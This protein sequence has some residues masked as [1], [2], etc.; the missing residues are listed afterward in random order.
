MRRRVGEAAR[1]IATVAVVCMLGVAPLAAG[2]Q[3]PGRGQPGPG[4]RRAQLEQRARQAYGRVLRERVG[5]TPD[6]VRQLGA[7]NQRLAPARQQ[8]MREERGTRQQLVQQVRL[9]SAADQGK[10]SALLAQLDTIQRRRLE[11]IEQEDRA[12]AAFMSPLQRAKYRALQ[13][14]VR[15]RMEP[16]RRGGPRRPVDFPLP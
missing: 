9:D 12:L 14:L 1:R 3:H 15:R 10:V 2:A 8:L 7:V 6:Q 5:L 13:E 4:P 16:A 11:L